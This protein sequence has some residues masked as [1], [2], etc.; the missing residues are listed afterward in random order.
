MARR[1]R[2]GANRQRPSK[3]CC[4]RGSNCPTCIVFCVSLQFLFLV[5]RFELSQLSTMADDGF[6]RELSKISNDLFRFLEDESL[7]KVRQHFKSIS[8]LHNE[9]SDLAE[10]TSVKKLHLDEDLRIFLG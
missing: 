7:H 8:K 5:T 6:D 4:W 9:I 10:K 3:S 1:R 2:V